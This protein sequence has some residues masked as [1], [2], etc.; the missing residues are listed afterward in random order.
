MGTLP[1]VITDTLLTLNEQQLLDL[2]AILVERIRLFQSAK[3]LQAMAHFNLG[4]TVTFTH[5]TEKIM[6]QITKLNQ[7]SVSVAGMD[8]RIWKVS[9][10]LLA[11]VGMG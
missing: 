2:H 6:G 10:G 5:N 11:K 9:P 8:G 4:D 1:T 7:K 3:H